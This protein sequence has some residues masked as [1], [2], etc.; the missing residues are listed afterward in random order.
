MII[1]TDFGTEAEVRRV[2]HESVGHGHKRINVEVEI[3]GRRKTFYATTDNMPDFD[4]AMDLDRQK[5][6]EEALLALVHDDIYSQVN[7][8]AFFL[9]D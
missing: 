4:K 7:E 1:E 9:Q 6:C 5:E 2:S 3:D 8:W